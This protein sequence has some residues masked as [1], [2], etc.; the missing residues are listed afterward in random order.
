MIT[1]SGLL[2]TDKVLHL[3]KK[4][5]SK[6]LQQEEDNMDEIVN[7]EKIWGK[8]VNL[9]DDV[10]AVILHLDIVEFLGPRHTPLTHHTK[11]IETQ[12]SAG[13]NNTIQCEHITIITES[14]G[15]HLIENLFSTLT[16]DDLN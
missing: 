7:M 15:D 8:E 13:N 9:V 14:L 11:V 4:L 12:H 5:S 1:P 2:E 3:N 6:N 10:V 16:S